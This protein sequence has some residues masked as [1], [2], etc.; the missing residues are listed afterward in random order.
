MNKFFYKQ[1]AP[2]LRSFSKLIGPVS[3]EL[4]DGGRFYFNLSRASFTGVQAY[5]FRDGE[6]SDPFETLIHPGCEMPEYD[7]NFTL[8]F[9]EVSDMRASLISKLINETS[10]PIVVQYSG[11]IDSTVA[12]VSLLKN[13]SQAEL[14]QIKIALSSDSLLESPNF[15]N[16]YLK[17]NFEILDSEALLF[18]QYLEDYNAF[19][20]SADTGDSIFGSE[21]GN[22]LY[23]KMKFISD[24]TDLKMLYE[25]VSNTDVPF[26]RYKDIVISYF[27]RN[28]KL[29]S[30]NLRQSVLHPKLGN[31][32]SED[33]SFGELF[34]EKIVRNIETSKVPIHSLHDFFWWTIFNGRFI[35]CTLR[36]PIT[37][38]LG[39]N[40]KDLINNCLI[41][42]FN[43]SE[44][45]QWSMKNNNNGEKLS[46]PVQGLCKT[47]AK[48]Y[49]FDF[50]KDHFY[51]H[52][53]IKIVSLTNII[54]RNWRKNYQ[55]FDPIFA[56]DNN[57]NT[58]R[59][60]DTKVN[61]FILDSI[62]RYKI[63]W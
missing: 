11:G 44:Y 49:I 10:R 58:V 26:S 17:N 1:F 57:Y 37:Y 54:N 41:Q 30:Q 32:T 24:D 42:W 40:K 28:L 43:S 5:M 20:I 51:F 6:W 39:D 63:D 56:V 4:T 18:N 8:S 52:H 36:A 27:N 38:A 60:G 53:K 61:D 29:G 35:F 62:F 50:T 22:K 12:I 16:K 23:P 47:A 55:D 14:R 2:H 3:D 59:I 31:L 46:G 34:Y 25:S 48:K 33:D 9:S 45:Q 7:P 15:F 13:L 19:C 21:L